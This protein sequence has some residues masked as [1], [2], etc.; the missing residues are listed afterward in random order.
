LTGRPENLRSSRAQEQKRSSDI[1]VFKEFEGGHVMALVSWRG[2]GPF[3]GLLEL[4]N[5]LAQALDNPDLGLG[6]GPSS[7]SVFPPLNVFVDKGGA[8]VV[9]AEIPGVDPEGIQIQVE[10]QRLTISG[11][12]ASDA[13]SAAYHR[14]ERRF[15]RFS[16]SVQIPADLDPEQA[17]AQYRD[18]LLTVRIEK[19]AAARPRKVAITTV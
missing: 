3:A 15:G 8:V 11:E 16:R 12:R 9:R 19:S 4:Q 14:R 7:A 6:R 13:E 17:T 2:F 10:P 1:D 5:A 18:G